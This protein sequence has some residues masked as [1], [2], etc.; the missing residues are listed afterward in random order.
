VEREDTNNYSDY[1]ENDLAD[2]QFAYRRI[3][4]LA[5]DRA[6]YIF[7]IPFAT[8]FATLDEAGG[9]RSLPLASD[10]AKLAD[11]FDNVVFLDLLKPTYRTAKRQG[12]KFVDFTLGC[13]GHWGLLGN[14]FVA[15]AI[16]DWLQ[17][18]KAYAASAD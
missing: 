18:R 4:E 10:L 2:M 11:G 17:K 7:L 1:T 3:I 8:E 5:G 13:D 16:Y 6:V 12:L 15:D 14:R 9:Y